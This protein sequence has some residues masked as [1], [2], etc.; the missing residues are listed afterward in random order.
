M[1]NLLTFKS[2]E[3]DD[4]SLFDTFLSC[5]SQE[6]SELNFTNLFIWKNYYKIRW[7]EYEGILVICG[8]KDGLSFLFQPVFRDINKDVAWKILRLMNDT[9]L[10]FQRVDQKFVSLFKNNVRYVINP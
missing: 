6:I 1:S 8:E 10:S 7:T 9:G 5:Y 4:K 2:L 3:L